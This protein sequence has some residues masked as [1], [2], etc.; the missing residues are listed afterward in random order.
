MTLQVSK[1]YI[2]SDESGGVIERCGKGVVGNSAESEC[3]DHY[4]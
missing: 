3:V 4:L 2:G 1:S